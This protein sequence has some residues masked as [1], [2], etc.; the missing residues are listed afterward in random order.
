MGYYYIGGIIWRMQ[1]YDRDV[2]SDH[3]L[4]SPGKAD[5]MK[6]SVCEIGGAMAPVN[7]DVQI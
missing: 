6:C 2:R 1:W 5:R 4:N 3:L 7:G